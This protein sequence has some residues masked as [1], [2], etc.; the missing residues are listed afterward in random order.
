VGWMLVR[1][2]YMW[3]S[4]VP[5]C[6]AAAAEWLHYPA[7]FAGQL[8]VAKQLTSAGA[9]VDAVTKVSPLLLT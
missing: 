8:E 7:P 3:H 9:S 4:D 1:W 2:V 5:S 6:G